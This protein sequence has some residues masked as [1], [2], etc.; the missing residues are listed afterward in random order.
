MSR[1]RCGPLLRLSGAAGSIYLPPLAS[2]RTPRRTAFRGRRS[3]E[4][5][6]R[7]MP[8]HMRQTRGRANGVRVA[9]PG[10]SPSR[11]ASGTSG[12]ERRTP[13]TASGAISCALGAERACPSRR[14]PPSARSRVH[15]RGR[16]GAA[17]RRALQRRQ[18]ET[19]MACGATPGA[20]AA[21]EHARPS[22]RVPTDRSGQ[23]RARR[24]PGSAAGRRAASTTSTGRR[25]ATLARCRNNVAARWIPCTRGEVL[26]LCLLHPV[27]GRL[28]IPHR[29]LT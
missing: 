27:E 7:L 21:F 6:A 16:P 14:F 22:L 2:V 13:T 23:P 28:L 20:R 24:A 4:P 29:N 26:A 5:L 8:G 25:S 11:S 19:S 18:H 10:T 12:T 9:R 3:R 15:Q 17:S 1:P